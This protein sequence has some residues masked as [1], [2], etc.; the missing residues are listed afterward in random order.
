MKIQV[1]T[2]D[3]VQG[4]AD[5]IRGVRQDLEKAVANFSSAITRIEAH[6]SD[7]NSAKG[8]KDK[9]CVLEARVK[10]MKPIAVTHQAQTLEF[11]VDGAAEKLKAAIGSML[12]RLSAR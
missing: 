3:D 2:G 1:N 9:R 11:A 12:G 4:S 10:G 6:L 7:E 5:L 8:G